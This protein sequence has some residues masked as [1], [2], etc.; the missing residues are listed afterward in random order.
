MSPA[1]REGKSVGKRPNILFIAVDD[2]R[3]E[4]G[5]YG[6]PYIKSP[7][8]DRLAESGIV[9]NRAYCQQAVCNPSRASLLSGMRPDSIKVW[10][11]RTHFRDT[12]PDV[13]TLPL[14][15]KLNGY[16]T[17]GIGKIFHGS[18]PDPISWTIPKMKPKGETRVWSDEILEEHKRFLEQ[19]RV[20]MEKSGQTPR[21]MRATAT[22][23]EDVPDNLRFDGAQTDVAI[24]KL[25]ELKDRSD[26]FFLAVG[27]VKPHLPFVAP[28]KYWDLYDRDTIPLADND[29]L[30]KDSPPMAMNTMYELRDYMDFLDTPAPSEGV[31][32]EE[33]QRLLKHGYYAC[34]SFVDF[35]I[36][37]LLGELDRLG[38]RQDTVIIL[39]GDHGWKLGEHRS[40]CKQTNYEIDTRSPLIICAPQSESKGETS[41]A[42]VEFL[43]IFPT[44]CDLA[45]LPLPGHLEGKSM[46]PLLDQPDQPWK[47]GAFSQFFR[48]HE[49]LPYMGHTIRTDR[50]RY[51][52]WCNLDT[53]ELVAKE[54][55]DHRGDPQ[56]NVNIADRPENRQI[57]TRLHRQLRE[58]CPA[59]EPGPRARGRKS[60]DSQEAVKLHIR[61][62]LEELATIYWIDRNGARRRICYLEPNEEHLIDTFRTHLFVALSESGTYDVV[63]RPE[64]YV[65]KTAVLKR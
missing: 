42:L 40:W 65:G 51:V 53:G 44:L 30:P 13:V 27:Y 23:C 7:N 59:L 11:L 20:R 64:D 33:H 17:A 35:Q 19:Y 57:V 4:L 15:F 10:D 58:T 29:F 47:E 9:F 62:Q 48:R 43:D 14:Y 16:Y 21:A 60:G 39:W 2:L 31:L 32:S 6:N 41:D 18:L 46:K 1:C 55:Y 63:I 12:T 5:C 24:E 61:N 3:L 28:K 22:S 45:G 25:R 50:Y 34:V 8:I 54:L 56:E 49:D 38:L 36:G 52:E 37:R 26:P